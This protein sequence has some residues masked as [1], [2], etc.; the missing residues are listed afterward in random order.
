MCA[1]LTVSF[2]F[3]YYGYCDPDVIKGATPASDVHAADMHGNANIGQ[4]AFYNARHLLLTRRF[5]IWLVLCGTYCF[6]VKLI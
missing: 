6:W 5:C 4:V 3:L 2:S 1:T